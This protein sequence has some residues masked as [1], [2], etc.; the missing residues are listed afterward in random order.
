MTVIRNRDLCLS[1]CLLIFWCS[2]LRQSSYRRLTF[3]PSRY[4]RYP[5][6]YLTHHY[7][8]CPRFSVLQLYEGDYYSSSQSPTTELSPADIFLSLL[9]SQLAII[10]QSTNV[11]H[12]AIYMSSEGDDYLDDEE[13]VMQLVCSYPPTLRTDDIDGIGSIRQEFNVNDIN[14]SAPNSVNAREYAADGRKDVAN[15]SGRPK[16]NKGAMKKDTRVVVE[17]DFVMDIADI[18]IDEDDILK[19]GW[20][21]PRGESTSTVYPIQFQG[22]NLGI[23][24]TMIN[25]PGIFDDAAQNIPVFD[26]YDY[27]SSSKASSWNPYNP[28]TR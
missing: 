8:R 5:A 27:R 15:N 18:E 23:L 10:V 24:Q 21:R 16:V 9:E 20:G 1:L 26:F 13:P 6:P 17:S 4:A 2:A 11:T 19:P 28:E 7:S 25:T 3:A 14:E 22:A 12:A